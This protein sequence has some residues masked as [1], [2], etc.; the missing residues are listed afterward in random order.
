MLRPRH[1]FAF[2]LALLFEVLGSVA[3]LVRAQTTWTTPLA[4]RQTVV[5]PQSLLLIPVPREPVWLLNAAARQD[6]DFARLLAK[7]RAYSALCNEL[8]SVANGWAV[9]ASWVDVEKGPEGIERIAPGLVTTNPQTLMSLVS[10]ARQYAMK[11]P[12][13]PELDAAVSGLAQLVE[14][15]P[16]VMNEAN[17]YY[18][19][20]DYLDD[21]FKGGHAY[22][23]QLIKTVPPLLAARD[24][25]MQQIAAL[26]E[27]LDA[28]EIDMIEAGNGRKYLWHSRR[29]LA[30]AGKL[31]PF[32]DW[33]P[34]KTRSEE[35]K[36]AVA[37]FAVAVRAFDDYRASPGA[38]HASGGSLGLL[39]KVREW[40]RGS[41]D[42]R[43]I[44]SVVNEYNSMVG[45]LEY[46]PDG[47]EM[48][49]SSDWPLPQAAPDR[50]EQAR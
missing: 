32:F 42:E 30:L 10:R 19:R 45:Q 38:E 47:M 12:L 46:G 22:H 21:D 29:V 37:E 8:M 24:V 5:K 25:V 31:A 26:G 1:L 2:S 36:A 20:K 40:R 34:E 33:K 27:K 4:D 48:S 17:A 49:R 15:V 13:L 9:Y 18:D 3:T 7:K 50:R 41:D 28:R 44:W 14:P 39:P 43:A 6:P 11:E 35:L 23:A 16:A